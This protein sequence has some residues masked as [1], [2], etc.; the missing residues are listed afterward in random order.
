MSEPIPGRCPVCGGAAIRASLTGL[1]DDRYGYPGRFD[2]FACAH[3]GHQFL[4][5]VFSA[6]KLQ[7]LYTNYYPRSQRNLDHWRP[8]REAHAFLLW[9]GRGRNAV[10]RWVPRAVKVLDV[11]CGF[12]ESLG[13]HRARGCEV[14]GVETDENILRVAQRFDFKVRVGVFRAGDFPRD[15]FDFVTLDQVIEHVADPVAFLR[16]AAA[17][18]RPGGT[19]LLS[20]PNARSPMARGLGRRWVHWH[21]PYH[22]QLFSKHSLAVAASAAGLRVRWCRNLTSPQW[23]HFQWLHLLS[24]P[25]PGVPSVFWTTGRKWPR[26]RWLARKFF[27]GLN[28]IGFN[29]AVSFCFDHLGRGDNL[30]MALE[31][32]R[33]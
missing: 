31:R 18:L 22:L 30:V 25:E 13:Y 9:L 20:T 17:V 24:R 8:H 33:E 3:C 29:H 10:F 14:W 21:A 7:H 15:Y 11:G 32:P 1:Y 6:E 5:A 19:L 16:D 27:S 23:Y 2:L 12:G 26:G 28:R 4:D